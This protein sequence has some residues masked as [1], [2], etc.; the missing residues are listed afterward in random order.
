VGYALKPVKVFRTNSY[1]LVGEGV[2]VTQKVVT[3][4]NSLSFQ[5]VLQLTEQ[6][7]GVGSKVPTAIVVFGGDK[8]GKSTLRHY[9]A[10]EKLLYRY[11]DLGF[12]EVVAEKEEMKGLEQE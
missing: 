2:K 3:R 5:R 12:N 8:T 1:L 9:L 11:N 10:G 7:L 4:V 6:A